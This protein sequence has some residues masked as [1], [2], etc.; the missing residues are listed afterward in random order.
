MWRY[1]I[2]SCK[3]IILKI[4]QGLTVDLDRYISEDLTKRKGVCSPLEID[5]ENLADEISNIA[6]LQER[7]TMI[8]CD[9]M[10][11]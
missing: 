11:G 6:D 10:V 1:W 8:Q 3:N 4:F 5:D 7:R 9:K 2:T